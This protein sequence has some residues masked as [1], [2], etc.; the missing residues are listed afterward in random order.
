MTA[1]R[2]IEKVTYNA[3]T[4]DEPV[5]D[6]GWRALNKDAQGFMRALIECGADPSLGEAAL[7]DL[8]AAKAIAG[9]LI[10][11]YPVIP[12]DKSSGLPMGRLPCHIVTPRDL[13]NFNE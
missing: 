3:G 4:E 11:E 8:V 2:I 5:Q 6:K 13:W 10:F 12:F 7:R 9:R 1:D